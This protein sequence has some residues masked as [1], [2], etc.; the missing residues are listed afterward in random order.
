MTTM[1]AEMCIQATVGKDECMDVGDVRRRY[2]DKTLA[3]ALEE[4]VGKAAQYID[5]TRIEKDL[6][7]NPGNQ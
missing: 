4:Q 7:N 5:L 3:E 1:E 6:L 2:R